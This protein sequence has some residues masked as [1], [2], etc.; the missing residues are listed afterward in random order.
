MVVREGA[1]VSLQ[2][3]ATGFPP[4]K[5]TW[6]REDKGKIT[7]ED[8]TGRKVILLIK[9]IKMFMKYKFILVDHIE[10]PYLNFTKVNRLHMGIYLCIASNFIPPTVS[11]R[12]SLI[13]HCNGKK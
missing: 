9:T 4:P 10:G 13:V 1:N 2:C 3:A 12:I 7:I 8:R 6:K 5:I 11:R